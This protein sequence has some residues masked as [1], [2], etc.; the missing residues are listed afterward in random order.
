[1]AQ[2]IQY[3]KAMPIDNHTPYYTVKPRQNHVLKANNQVLQV[4]SGT[5]W[6][7]N[8]QQDFVL[9]SGEAITLEKGGDAVVAVSGLFG[10]PVRY[11][12]TD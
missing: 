10:K 8:N 2:A 7:S 1:M 9:K 12:V 3:I 6:V 4:I 11:T 5:A